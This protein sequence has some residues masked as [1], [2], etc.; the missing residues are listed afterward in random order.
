MITVLDQF[1]NVDSAFYG[2]KLHMHERHY[3]MLHRLANVALWIDGM[4][5][6]NNFQMCEL[7]DF[8]NLFDTKAHLDIA[9]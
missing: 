9:A 8:G 7:S 3:L 2:V 1:Q 4:A 5:T 6:A